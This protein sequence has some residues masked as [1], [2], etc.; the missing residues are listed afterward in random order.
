MNTL[1]AMLDKTHTFSKK[2]GK[3]GS[4]TDILMAH[5]K[6]EDSWL[7]FLDPVKYPE[8]IKGLCRSLNLA[9]MIFLNVDELDK[10]LGEM[11]LAAHLSEKP[12]V[13]FSSIYSKED[14]SSFIA[15]TNLKDWKF[16]DSETDEILNDLIKKTNNESKELEIAI[17]QVFPVKGIGVV[18]LGTVL[19]GEIN[20]RDTVKLL[21]SGVLTEV[22]SIQVHDVDVKTANSGD[23]VGLSLKNVVVDKIKDDSLLVSKNNMEWQTTENEITIKFNQSLIKNPLPPVVHLSYLLAD[24]VVRIV[25]QKENQLTVKSENLMI[26]KKGVKGLVYQPDTVPRVNASFEF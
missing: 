3:R 17:D 13:L 26:V 5:K 21:P 22:R 4:E 8:K 9:D 6:I 23:R 18:L 14:I 7:T 15:K 10:T 11:I 19:S 2:F 25:E 1:I 24:S 16:Y 12:G 20:V